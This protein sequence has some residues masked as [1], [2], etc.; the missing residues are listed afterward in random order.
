[1]L[2]NSFPYL[3]GLLPVSLLCFYL[4]ARFHRG[5]PIATLIIF[6]AIFY[7][8]W[9]V[10]Y[11][12]LGAI[13]I[14]FT[15]GHFVGS[16]RNF[17]LLVTGIALNLGLLGF[18]KYTDF[19]LEN[20]NR[21]A[22][23]DFGLLHLVLPLGISF[24]TFQQIAYLVDRHRGIIAG[25]EP[26][27]YLAFVLFYPQLIA[28]PIVNYREIGD[29]CARIRQGLLG[30]IGQNLVIGLFIFSLGLFKK[31]A[32]AD[33]FALSY[34]LQ[35]YFDFSGYVDMA[36]GLA[37][38]FGIVFPQNFDSPYRATSIIDFWRR[39]HITLSHF[40]RDYLYI[41]LGGRRRGFP[42]Q[43]ANLMATMLLGGLWHGASWAFI[44]WGGLHG[45]MLVINHSMRR[46]LPRLTVPRFVA[47]PVTFLAVVIVWVPFRAEPFSA[48]VTLG[49]AMV[50]IDAAWAE[51]V[52]AARA[53][54][55][56]Q[57]REPAGWAYDL[58]GLG[59]CV[60]AAAAL[61]LVWAAPNSAQLAARL[62]ASLTAKQ[63]DAGW[64]GRWLAWSG[65]VFAVGLLLMNAGRVSEFLYFQ[66]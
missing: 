21:L 49:R 11:L 43:M 31:T 55:P 47:I 6:S 10:G 34:A 61:A 60:L 19:A 50:Q 63:P 36:I 39:W 58:Y 38:M 24:H 41:P 4:S 8:T 48:T 45:A 64:V 53:I 59:W 12:M 54:T 57:L 40:L 5:L 25:A 1:M 17:P 22:G 52:A 51:L 32:V 9:S 65:V 27:Q 35:I 14:N 42:R 15:L 29:Q 20:W 44:L 16:G 26:T 28:G 56:V 18:F 3:F 23:T 7:G 37:R 66:F 46:W 33:T 13:V 2:F 62:E 30:P